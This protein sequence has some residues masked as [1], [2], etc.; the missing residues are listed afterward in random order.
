VALALSLYDVAEKFAI[1][2]GIIDLIIAMT[3]SV[4]VFSIIVQGLTIRKVFDMAYKNDPPG[5]QG[6]AQP[7]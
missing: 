1:D 3:Y 7:H 2:R 5:G 4:V 6:Q